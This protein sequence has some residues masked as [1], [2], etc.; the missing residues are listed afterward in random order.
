LSL[1]QGVISAEG[2]SRDGIEICTWE[3]N[4]ERIR[5][6]RAIENAQR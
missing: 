6:L 1:Y 5:W 3:A 4:T 2:D